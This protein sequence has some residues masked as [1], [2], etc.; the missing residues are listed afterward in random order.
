MLRKYLGVLAILASVVYRHYW[1]CYARQWRRQVVKYQVHTLGI[2]SD[3]RFVAL[4]AD[5]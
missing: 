3:Y 1:G 5:W 4:C 2:K